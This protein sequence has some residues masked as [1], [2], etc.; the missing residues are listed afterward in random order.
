MLHEI[1]DVLTQLS[2]G[3]EEREDEIFQGDGT[4]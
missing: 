2:M 1:S 3:K 4:G